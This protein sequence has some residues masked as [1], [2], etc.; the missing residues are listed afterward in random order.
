MARR[1]PAILVAAALAVPSALGQQAERPRADAS[2]KPRTEII[3]FNAVVVT[4][5]VDRPGISCTVV[6]S[7]P[8][9]G[10]QIVRRDNFQ[11]E[12]ALSTDNL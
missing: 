9:F 8:V 3:D 5:A 2:R 6:P 7:R 4:G 1:V 12:L 11:R 10:T